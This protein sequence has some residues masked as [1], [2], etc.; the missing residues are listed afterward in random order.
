VVHRDLKPSNVIIRAD[1]RPV[2]LDFGVALD[3][4][5]AAPAITE[6]HSTPGTIFYMSP[7]QLRGRRADVDRRSD[8]YSLGAV[9]YEMLT[10]RRAIG[11][12][13]TDAAI[14]QI[15][16]GYIDRPR[17]GAEE[18]PLD[19]EA[20]CMMALEQKPARRYASA[21]ELAEDLRR[22]IDGRPTVARPL[23]PLTRG[24]RWVRRNPILSAMGTLTIVAA[25]AA[26]IG[27]TLFSGERA[28]GQKQLDE[29]T[30]QYAFVG[31]TLLLAADDGGISDDRL[32]RLR[33]ILGDEY[34][35][36]LLVSGR[37]D[38]RQFRDVLARIR[39][40]TRGGVPED[41]T[42]TPLSPVGGV[43]GDRPVFRFRIEQLA[44]PN[45][46][47][48]VAVDLEEGERVIGTAVART[49]GET[50]EVVLP[51]DVRLKPGVT[52]DWCVRPV[53][54]DDLNWWKTLYP[55]FTPVDPARHAAALRAL[56]K[57]GNA[58]VDALLRA[59][60][61][62]SLGLGQAALDELAM[63]PSDARLERQHLMLEA[64]ARQM[65]GDVDGAATIAEKL[66]PQPQ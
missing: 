8:V 61:C 9:L 5:S 59:T 29:V 50:L 19:V 49:A 33:E 58:G 65:V 12:T 16:G 20:V 36:R 48:E 56:R 45:V 60:A 11:A 32:R 28:H 37:I 35:E 42:F 27:L 18:I 10:L 14:A 22:C 23:T 52:V 63:A 25:I 54:A 41:V 24:A 38:G 4:E 64:Q 15:L 1:G 21:L 26:A 3:R 31:E 53:S 40:S 47:L 55:R 17:R 51:D 13:E 39:S 44:R 57:T 2:V 34:V 62:L 46:K 7:E 43:L 66:F 6:G 30:D